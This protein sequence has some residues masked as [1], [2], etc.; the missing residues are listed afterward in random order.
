MIW[1]LLF[2]AALAIFLSALL[3]AAEAAAFAVGSSRLRTLEEEGFRGA[4]ALADLKA[5]PEQ[6]RGSLLVLT[7]I[8][9][10]CT[11]GISVIA[12]TLIRGTSG[13]AVGLLA[14][15]IVV[16]IVGQILPRFLATARPLRLALGAAPLLVFVEGAVETVTRPFARISG[17]LARRNGNEGSTEDERAVREISELGQEEGLIGV[18][19]HLLVERAFRLDEL[20]AWDVMTPRVDIFAWKDTL[21]LQ[22]IV[23]ELA[24]VPY[25]RVPVYHETPDDISGILYVREAYEHYVAGRTSMTLGQLSREPLFVPGSLPL[26]RLLGQFQAHRIHM[27]IISDEF[28]GT[29]G[30]A[31]LEDILEELVG[32]IVDETDEDEEALVRVSRTQVEAPGGMDVREINHAFNVTLPQLEHRSLNGFIL[33]ELGQVPETGETL[34][35]AGVRIE[36]LEATD[37]QVIRARLTKVPVT[38]REE[39]G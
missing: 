14:G 13:G 6:V 28:G 35:R 8:L 1:L 36:I 30:L 2:A 22:E 20:T 4:E 23:A 33:E 21:T 16:L 7:T 12:G 32:E 37:T 34:D 29:D 10:V 17:L 24:T 18:E 9:N 19:E 3:A 25:S 15:G 38:D 27:G 39:T 5:R 31:T 26:T 11:V